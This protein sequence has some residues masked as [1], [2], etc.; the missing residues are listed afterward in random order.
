V[1]TQRA[2]LRWLLL[3]LAALPLAA[4]QA[5]NLPDLGER[6][7]ADLS[8]Q[9]EKRIGEAI[10]R[11]IRRDPDYLDDPEIA[12]YVQ[13]TGRKLVGASGETRQEFEFFVVRD[14]TV[15]AFALP[16]GFVG[17]HTGLLLTAQDE[18]EFAGVL[19]HEIAH[20]LQRHSA[21][22]LEAAN[23]LTPIALLGLGLAV[24]AARASPQAAQAAVIASQ[25]APTAAMLGY[26]RDFEREADRVGFQILQGSGYD[27]NGM[28]SFFERLQKSTRLYD[29]NAPTYLRTHPVT[30]ERIGDMQSRVKDAPYRQRPDSIDFQLVRAKLRANDGKPD[31]AVAFFRGAIAERRFAVEGP[32]YYGYAAALARANNFKAAETELAKARAAGPANSMYETLAARIR[33]G[34]GDRT[35]AEKILAAALQTYPDA[36][37]VRYDYADALQSVG[38]NAQAI[39]VLKPIAAAPGA[40]PRAYR[41]IARS[42][43]ALGKR[44]EQHRALAEAYYLQGGLAAAAEQLVLAQSAGDADFYTLSAIDARLRE[45]RRQLQ[46]ELKNRKR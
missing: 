43:G 13:A 25:A 36:L 45:V 21:R 40:E 22:Q 32:A 41:A 42:Y 17:V 4:G 14:R 15:N 35:G 2:P 18:S 31:D 6:S 16:G 27:V 7:Q 20:V 34:L 30:S 33:T 11:E 28:A 24:L 9:Q 37:A 12:A 5:Q 44:T 8:P 46:E 23:Q 38:K 19:A 26:S 10:M 29:N 1:R 39:E 3:A